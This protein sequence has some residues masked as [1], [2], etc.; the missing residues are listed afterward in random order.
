MKNSECEMKLWRCI[1]RSRTDTQ[2]VT[3]YIPSV[4]RP[5]IEH[6]AGVFES[7]GHTYDLGLHKSYVRSVFD[8]V[9]EERLKAIR[10]LFEADKALADNMA[11]LLLLFDRESNPETKR[12]IEKLMDF[13]KETARQQNKLS[14]DELKA[15][16]DKE[17]AEERERAVNEWYRNGAGESGYDSNG[18]WC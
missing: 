2:D 4:T 17:K 12:G 11:E 15:I 13:V 6:I 18:P 7:M 1:V 3:F 16:S 5:S 10:H 9:F 14:M 8:N